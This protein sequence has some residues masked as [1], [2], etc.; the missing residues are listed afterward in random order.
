MCRKSFVLISV[1]TYGKHDRE[2]YFSV[3]LVF[4]DIAIVCSKFLQKYFGF[5]LEFSQNFLTMSKVFYK[6]RLHSAQIYFGVISILYWKLC[7]KFSKFLVCSKIFSEFS[8][9]Y[10][11]NFLLKIFFLS[12]SLNL[13]QNLHKISSEIQS[14]NSVYTYYALIIT[15]HLWSR[16]MSNGIPW[17]VR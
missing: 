14:M 3:N 11:N 9:I 10:L 1:V 7:K 8:S 13:T 15:L 4:W 16:E 6:M 2:P 5:S 12:F 17:L